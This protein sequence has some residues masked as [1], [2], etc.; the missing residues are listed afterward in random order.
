MKVND[1]DTLYMLNVVIRDMERDGCFLVAHL[2]G[3]R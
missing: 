1:Q 2:E 3:Q